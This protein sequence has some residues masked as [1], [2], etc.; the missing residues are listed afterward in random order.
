VSTR[1][2]LGDPRFTVGEE[3]AHG[4]MSVV[5]A[6]LDGGGRRVAIK[7]CRGNDPGI[8]L[9]LSR[10]ATMLA[11][12]AHPFIVSLHGSGTSPDGEPWLVTGFV[13]GETLEQKLKRD[14]RSWPRL[15]RHVVDVAEAMAYAH[16][17]GVVHRDLKPHNVLVD[18]Q[19]RTV[20]I[21][22]GLAREP[23]V[24]AAPPEPGLSITLPGGAVGTP[25][26]WSPEQRAG[27]VVDPRSDVYSVGAMLFRMIT[28]RPALPVVPMDEM[29][30]RALAAAPPRLRHVVA[31]ATALDADKRYQTMGQLARELRRCARAG[32]RRWIVVAVAVALLALACVLVLG[33]IFSS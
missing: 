31:R 12:L 1:V 32:S 30:E 28:G 8:A 25:G 7:V 4:G 14:P 10:E 19:G 26:Y 13:D 20:I 11:R 3:L 27:D 5:H 9:R 33:G 15:L 22:W 6:G 17:R 29:L 24:G 18:A 23:E 2:D 16:A 21:D